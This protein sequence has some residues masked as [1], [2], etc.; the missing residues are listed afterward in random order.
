MAEQPDAR[1]QYESARKALIE[2][3]QKKR[4]AD[5]ALVRAYEPQRA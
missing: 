2:A 3:I 4:A 5:K 1:L